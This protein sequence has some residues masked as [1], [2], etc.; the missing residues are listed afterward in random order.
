MWRIFSR[1]ALV[2]ASADGRLD[3]ANSFVESNADNTLC[4]ARPQSSNRITNIEEQRWMDYTWKQGGKQVKGD[5]FIF[6]SH[7]FF[8]LK[9]LRER[10]ARASCTENM[11]FVVNQDAFKSTS[12][13]HRKVQTEE[14]RKRRPN[15]R[16]RTTTSLVKCLLWLSGT[17]FGL[18]SGCTWEKWESGATLWLTWERKRG[19]KCKK[20]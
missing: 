2:A 7:G 15:C 13:R 12:V 14:K 6:I 3:W 19:K 4:R 8:F 1:K 16:R 17:I 18:R 9:K 20:K 11:Q 5:K 10:P